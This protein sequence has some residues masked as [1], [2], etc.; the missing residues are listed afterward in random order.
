MI[1]K[2]P[3]FMTALII[4]VMALSGCGAVSSKI[5]DEIGEKIIENA[6][7]DDVDVEVEDDKITIQDNEGNSTVIDSSGSQPWPDSL[8]D[9]LPVFDGNIVGSMNIQGAIMLTIEDVDAE[10]AADY[11]KEV[12]KAGYEQQMETN[13]Q[14]SLYGIYQKDNAMVT[15]TY[16]DDESVMTITYAKE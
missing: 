15:I 3:L 16:T 8:P 7:G 13:A 9:D 6:A 10:D 5:G 4:I 14:G 1:K 11:I 12:K 2:L